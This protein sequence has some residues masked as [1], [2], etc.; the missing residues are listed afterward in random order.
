MPFKL[1]CLPLTDYESSEE[2]SSGEEEG[3][4][5]QQKGE[6]EDGDVLMTNPGLAHSGG[7]ILEF[8]LYYSF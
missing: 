6:D 2:G 8:I 4:E 3:V 7:G 5:S 1:C